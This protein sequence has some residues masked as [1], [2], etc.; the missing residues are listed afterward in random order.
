M[1]KRVSR[2]SVR[3]RFRKICYRRH[4]DAGDLCIIRCIFLYL[5]MRKTAADDTVYKY[6]KSIEIQPGG[7]ALG[8]R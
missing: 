1:K 3:R 6:Y 2:N 7:Y 8:D 5:H 4:F